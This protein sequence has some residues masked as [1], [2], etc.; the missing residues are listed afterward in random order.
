VLDDIL[1]QQ[2]D[3]LVMASVALSAGIAARCDAAG[4]PVVL[5]NR[6]Q[7]DPALWAVTSDN[8][9]GARQ[10]ARFLAAGGHRRIALLA[11]WDGASTARDR[12]AGFREGL[13]ESGLPLFARGAGEYA[14]GP[15]RAATL[16]MFAGTE[17]PDALFVANDHMAFAAMDA[18]RFELGLRVP[19]DVSVVGFDDAP[20]AAWPAYALTTVRQDAGAMVAD[21]VRLLLARI[22]GEAA[23]PRRVTVPA[24]LVLRRS[25]RI[26]EGWT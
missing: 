5:F 2:V 16:A 11:G 8:R 18:L 7:D 17:R 13:A 4:V 21:T 23:E 10:V 26:P 1:D 25:A 22:E 20:V 15:A 9:E 12:E 6:A 14:Q 19:E 24:P 3:G